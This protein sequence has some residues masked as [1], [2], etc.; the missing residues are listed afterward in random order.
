MAS[1]DGNILYNDGSKTWTAAAGDLLMAYLDG[2]QGQ[3]GGMWPGAWMKKDSL[4][5]TLH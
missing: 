2:V 3:F 5:R 4:S 1:V